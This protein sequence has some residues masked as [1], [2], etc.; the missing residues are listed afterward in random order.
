[1]RFMNIGLASLKFEVLFQ[2][3]TASFRRHGMIDRPSSISMGL[4]TL[5]LPLLSAL[6]PSAASAD[7]DLLPKFNAVQANGYNVIFEL[8]DDVVNGQVKGSAHY[9]ADADLHQVNGQA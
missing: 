8:N 7:C 1:M 6:L 5:A 4:I 9:L 2:A 3:A